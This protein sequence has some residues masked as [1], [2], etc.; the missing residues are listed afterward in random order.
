[1][2]TLANFTLG[3]HTHTHIKKKKSKKKFTKSHKLVEEDLFFP[4]TPV[5]KDCF[6]RPLQTVI[7]Q[8]ITYSNGFIEHS[9]NIRGF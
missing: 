1:M 5:K 2:K 4:I 6:K 9:F 7:L 3:F 8:K